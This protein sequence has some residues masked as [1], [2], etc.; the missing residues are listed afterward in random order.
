MA[1]LSITGKII[2]LDESEILFKDDF[3]NNADN[4]GWV[5][6][7]NISTTIKNGEI[8]LKWQPGNSLNHGQIFSEQVFPSDVVLEF[9]VETVPPSDHDIIWWWNAQMDQPATDW[10]NGYLAAL[11]GWFTNQAGVEKISK[12]GRC[13]T[14]RTPLFR[15][16]SG[17]NYKVQ[18]GRIGDTSFLF[19]DD[20]LIVEFQETEKINDSCGRIGFG[21]YQ[22]HF[23]VKRLKVFRPKFETVKLIY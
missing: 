9:E 7:G 5:K 21:V 1:K 3:N 16:E 6:T 20:K 19:V 2:N 23:K 12:T 11:G 15:L 8:E 10:D 22:S 18:S 4:A 13:Q 14:A 17:R